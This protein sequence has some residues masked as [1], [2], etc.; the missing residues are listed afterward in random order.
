MDNSKTDKIL[1]LTPMLVFMVLYLGVSLFT[2]DFYS[3]P[4][5]VAFL[6]AAIYSVLITRHHSLS[7]R[8]R[9]FSL[10]AG[11]PDMLLMIWIFVLAGA[12]S[13]S[14]KAVGA[15]DAAT[16]LTLRVLPAN[17]ILPGFFLAACFISISVGTSVG[18][19]VALAPIAAGIAPEIGCS[20][21]LMLAS[22][23]SGAYFGD[24]LSFIS[25]TTIIATQSQ[26]CR[27][28]DKFLFNF[29][30]VLPAALL[31]FGIYA[32]LGRDLVAMEN[33]TMTGGYR[34]LPY[35]VVFVSALMG[36]NVVLVLSLGLLCTFALSLM[37]SELSLL[38]YV[39]SMNAGILSMGE[40]IIITMM[41]GGVVAM[42][43][44]GGGLDYLIRIL[45]RHIHSA[46]GAEWCI[47]GLV[48]VADFCTANNTVAILSTGSIAKNIAEEY[49]IDPRRSASLLDIFGCF[50]QGCLPYGAQLVMLA[51]LTGVQPLEVIPFLYYPM[52]LGVA[53]IISIYWPVEHD[54]PLFLTRLKGLF[55]RQG[56]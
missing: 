8:L 10:G 18:T 50:A 31:V 9:E 11:N 4:L 40:L 53:G 24:N 26:G 55:H 44:L 17:F 12:F 33:I 19:I 36:M 21:P 27:M 42:M 41:A 16:A 3:M 54:T 35:V 52:A 22:V 43:K 51:G 28:R 2:G 29:R 25:D 6:I 15:I 34:V 45:T 5:V 46:R 30:I 38:E 49:D 47:A 14:A 32:Y 13:A 20:T 23:V 48:V 7:K 56:K 39:S 1:S 37:G